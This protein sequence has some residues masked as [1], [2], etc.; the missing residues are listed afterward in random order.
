MSYAGYYL[1]RNHVGVTDGK[2][3]MAERV[4][5]RL[6]YAGINLKRKLEQMGPIDFPALAWDKSADQEAKCQCGHVYY[7]HFD[8]YDYMYPVGCKYCDCA[9]FKKDESK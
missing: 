1:I 5:A 6:Y 8:T 3:I 2:A 7:R 9:E 4:Y